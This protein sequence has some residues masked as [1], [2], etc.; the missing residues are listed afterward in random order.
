MRKM[1]SLLI[2][3]TLLLSIG[4]ATTGTMRNASLDEGIPRTFAASFDLVLKAARESVTQSGLQ[5]E[6]VNQ[7][8]DETWVIIGKKDASAWSWGELVRVTV[9]KK[10]E[11]ETLV[12]VFTKRKLATNITAKGDY[13]H[14]I[15]SN[16]DL[17]LR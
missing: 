12:R 9:Q 7:L 15:L 17:N 14:S 10:S 8:D 6:E 13:S 4:C 11:S 2:M 3:V 5:V 1:M 16:I